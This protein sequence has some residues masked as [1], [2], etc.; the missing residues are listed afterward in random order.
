M[1][2]FAISIPKPCHEDWNKMTPDAKG[3]FCGSCQKSV[4]DFSDKSDEEI[5]AVFEK[6]EKGKVCGR[7][8]PAQ[9]TRPVI[10]F[11]NETSTS[12]RLAVFLYALLLAF[13]ATLFSGAEAF[14]QEVKGDVKVKVMGKM[15][16]HP[17]KPVEQVANDTVIQDKQI[18]PKVCSGTTTIQL[19][20]KI[21]PLGQAIYREEPVVVKSIGDT[22]I[23]EIKNDNNVTVVSV[24]ETPETIDTIPTIIETILPIDTVANIPEPMIYDRI[25]GGIS[26]IESYIEPVQVVD[27]TED[28]TEEKPISCELFTDIPTEVAREDNPFICVLTSVPTEDKPVVTEEIIKQDNSIIEEEVIEDNTKAFVETIL[29]PSDLEV[30]VSPNPSSGQITLT[31]TL[32]TTM[33]V[34]IDLYDITGK[35]VKT[36]TQQGNQYAGKYNVSYNISDLQNGIYFATLMTNDKKSSAKIIL[37]K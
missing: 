28:I 36:L 30:K 23:T 24:I 3:A 13:G 26:I 5:I 34:R 29:P 37:T 22:V 35:F 11:G 4:Y 21:M 2:T 1:K 31:Y 8:A 17:I 18:E 12:S 15:A 16:Y 20:A 19:D 27:P 14:A 25:M 32:E 9:L 7:F 33:P 6:E 10:S